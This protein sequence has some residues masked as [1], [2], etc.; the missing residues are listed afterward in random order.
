M[1]LCFFSFSLAGVPFAFAALRSSVD[2]DLSD[3]ETPPRIG[4]AAII[5]LSTEGETAFLL[6]EIGEGRGE[7]SGDGVSAAAAAAFAI[8]NC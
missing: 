3:D 2:D 4:E 8:G 6:S 5:R 7:G 1:S